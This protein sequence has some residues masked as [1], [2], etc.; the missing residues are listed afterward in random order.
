VTDAAT[1]D[2][3]E[4]F[5]P[6]LGVEAARA[7]V[8]SDA[9]R[10]S[11][12]G[13]WRFRLSPRADVPEDLAE[14][15]L[16]D[17]EW[18]SIPVP[19]MWQLEGHGSPAY[20]NI[21]YPFPLDPPR[22][23]DDN[24]TGDYRR[25]FTVPV[26]WDPEAAARV[27]LRFEGIDSL[28]RVWLN[29]EL[30]GVTS[31]SRLPTEFDVTD[32]V[33]RDEPNTLAVR[34]HQWSSG[35]Y[36][37]D[38]DL[39]WMS[40]IFRDVAL[41]ARPADA[42]VDYFVHADFDHATG[43][44]SLTVDATTSSGLPARVT[45]SELGIDAAAGETV[46]VEVE[47][48]SA[49]VP[50]L[51]SG[52]L[53]SGGEAIPLRIGFRRVQI[54]DGILTVNG[55]RVL[56]RGVNRHEFDPDHGRTVSEEL[57]VRDI[58]L[59]KQH[60]INAVRTSHYPP[61]P[62]FLEL[63]DEYG[64]WVID[65][66]DLE[67]HG[68]FVE[69]DQPMPGNPVTVPA[70][71]DALVDRM[72]RMVE[73]DKNHPSIIV[74][75]LGNECGPGVNLH[76][77][78]SW[79]KLRDPSRVIHYERDHSFP[80]SDLF[81]LM[82]ATHAEVDAIGRY[83]E[84]ALDDSDLDAHRRGLPF[85]L[86]E[87][88]HAMGNGPGGLT[89][90]QDLFDKYPR[91]QGGF[92]WEWIDHGLRSK[93]PDG[94]PFFAYGGDFGEVLHDA[95]FVADGLLFPDRTPSPGLLE[96]KKVIEPV[97]ITAEDDG[98]RVSNL[99]STLALDH[100]SFGWRLEEDGMPVARGVLEVP[101]VAH[102]D[103]IVVPLPAGLPTVETEGWL[104]I[105][106]S[107]ADAAP[108]APAGH[109]VAIAQI[110]LSTSVAGGT[111]PDA[112]GPGDRVVLDDELTLG[113]AT[114]DAATGALRRIDGVDVD[115]PVL[116]VWRAPIDNDRSFA[117]DPI[118]PGWRRVGL[119]R[120]IWRVDSVEILDDAI[121]VTARLAPAATT[122]GFRVRQRWTSTDG[123]L[124]LDLHVEPEGEWP[125]VLP[126]VGIRLR[127]PGTLD[128][129]G[130]FGLGP[131]ESYPDSRRA[132]TVGRYVRDVDELQTPYVFPQENGLRQDVRWVTVT[133]VAGK[134]IR[135]AADSPFGFTARRWTSADLDAAK[136]TVELK[137]GP[138]VWLN[139]DLA[140]QGLGTASCGPGVLPP[141]ELAAAI[142]DRTFF[143][144]AI[145]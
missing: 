26:D 23:P 79:A 91:C 94:T 131:G 15:A 58:V 24:P 8:V 71:E 19:S 118:E 47:P 93:L 25:T 63:C 37:E 59:M 106:A 87:Y 110:R 49:E 83:E 111:A 50:R 140:D 105:V 96:Y 73:R 34:V 13:S 21:K 64:L 144:T 76:A 116:D 4:A 89:E 99:Y 52:E 60:N 126:R 32:V 68:F 85:I 102:G 22:V 1:R 72:R 16:D 113:D 103:S 10:L 5:F 48:W 3:L 112:T 117:G 86:C 44:G 129:V 39:W 61:H 95:N 145:S 66:C 121:A 11:L 18:D 38:Q 142:F 143:F 123:H 130:W 90:Y 101:D 119:D 100:L 6:A 56:F 132:V 70:W 46:T 120:A 29:G 53:R 133:D 62:R 139:L 141:Y 14:E 88:A 124:R 109:P 36:L 9:P 42:V 51:Y 107:L 84:P 80:D 128:Q 28:A 30:L 55:E 114:F 98:L 82:Y 127:L 69:W 136:H 33:R 54:A 7:W 74:W 27:L 67:T 41:L 104:T 77:M 65:E 138:N 137:A 20:T 78:S 97:R 43:T 75:S 122:L 81:S 135:V 17:S 31:G 134:G 40:G 92:V 12:N 115:G 2:Y 57:M 108:W 35:S 125:T 45:V